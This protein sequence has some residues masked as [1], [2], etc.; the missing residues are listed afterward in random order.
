MI[1]R[2]RVAIAKK[3][4]RFPTT[5]LIVAT[6]ILLRWSASHILHSNPPPFLTYYPA[7]T[8]VAVVAGMWPGI[9]ASVLTAL[10]TL[11][12][13]LGL[14]ATLSLR[15]PAD[16]V[17]FLGFIAF[18]TL[19]SL[20]AETQRRSEHR[21]EAELKDQAVREVRQARRESEDRIRAVFDA[22]EEGIGFVDTAGSILESN[23]AS[24]NIL[25][26]AMPNL[27]DERLSHLRWLERP[28]GTRIDPPDHPVAIVL[29]TQKPLHNFEMCIHRSDGS[30]TWLNLN[31]RP[32]HDPAGHLLGAVS[33]FSDITSRKAMEQALRAGKRRLALF[34]EHAPVALAVFDRDM[35]F[36]MVSR[37][38]I[39]D[40]N[41][42]DRTLIGEPLADLFPGIAARWQ[43]AHRLCLAGQIVRNEQD[44]FLAADGSIHFLRWEIHP[45]LDLDANIAGFEIFAEDITDRVH[46]QKELLRAEERFS[47]AFRSSPLPISITVVSTGRYLDVNDAYL[48]LVP[49]SRQQLLQMTATEAGFWTDP[50]E[51]TLVLEDLA[52]NGRI[53]SRS[54]KFKSA[55]R[56]ARD[57]EFTADIIELEGQS[58]ILSISRDV[59]ENVELETQLRQA[60][61][62]EAIGLLAG[63]VAHDFNNLL[64]VILG[65]CDLAAP[66]IAPGTQIARSFDHVRMAA[67]R[68]ADLTRRLLALGRQ[69]I[70][71]P[72]PIHVNPTLKAIFD[73][74]RRVVNEDITMDFKPGA[75]AGS[76]LADPLQIEQI[77]MNLIINA[78]DAMPD[79]G[80]IYIST[81]LRVLNERDLT[82]FPGARPQPYAVIEVIDS[83]CGMDEA[84]RTQIFDPFF[85]TKPLGKGTGLGLSTV[86]G[87]VRQSGGFIHVTS[88]PGEGSR[89]TLIFPQV[90]QATRIKPAPLPLPA[91]RAALRTVLVVEDD[92]GLR[93]L[94][95]EILKRNAFS[96]SQASSGEEALTF[97]RQAN[98]PPEIMLSDV[99]MPGLNGVELVRQVTT[100]FPT[101]RILFMSGYSQELVEQRG[102]ILSEN[103]FIQKPFTISD[104]L[105]KMDALLAAT[106]ALTNAT[107]V[108]VEQYS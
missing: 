49:Y 9:L 61:K 23:T 73:L 92:S 15:T 52:R 56:Q 83:G 80:K 78:R 99:V 39:T 76:I 36:L 10:A 101:L 2:V 38:W 59:T 28:D 19:I 45:W 96:V 57:L 94:L 75:D 74:L 65:N 91:L 5:L 60:H 72:R 21:R 95:F 4:L 71:F 8:V 13:T 108:E 17:T 51:R 43:E 58:C 64:G 22:I 37:R 30:S 100:E 27:A 81:R 50:A 29:R 26:Y 107:A 105:A 14:R 85:T 16:L 35:R 55:S 31:V 44:E 47:K 6:A 82:A 32:L 97:L 67:E 90:L 1:S 54:M 48:E 12:P 86:Y 34:I 68:A 53:K 24:L 46:A 104:L 103:N 42:E 7:V 88:R 25:G 3:R 93:E 98:S 63:G 84:T 62:M 33:S 89:F 70:A 11:V 41:L 18:G 106:P 40:F 102:P 77:V 79:G 20:L 66:F 87:I 69:Q